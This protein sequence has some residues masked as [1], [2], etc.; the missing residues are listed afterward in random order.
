[1]YSVSSL[2]VKVVSGPGVSFLDVRDQ[3]PAGRHFPIIRVL[4]GA[5][6]VTL[7]VATRL[8]ISVDATPRLFVDQLNVASLPTTQRLTLGFR[9]TDDLSG[10]GAGFF[11]DVFALELQDPTGQLQ[12]VYANCQL[13]G[14][15]V[16]NPRIVV[17][18]AGDASPPTL[19]AVSI[20]NVAQLVSTTLRLVDTPG[21][22]GFVRIEYRSRETTQFQHCFAEL[23]TGD[24]QDGEWGCDINFPAAAASGIR[25]L[26]LEVVDHTNNRRFYSV[27]RSGWSAPQYRGAGTRRFLSGGILRATSSGCALHVRSASQPRLPHAHAIARRVGPLRHF[28][29]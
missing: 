3:S 2:K 11:F 1:M 17:G 25:D 23:R 4:P 6:D 18:G 29:P 14:G 10:A 5:N 20:T 27:R 7:P 21:G 24:D 19:E 26:F 16:V 13:T 8:G 12:L 9:V 28:T 22:V 15:C